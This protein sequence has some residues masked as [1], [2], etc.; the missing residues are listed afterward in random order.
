MYPDLGQENTKCRMKETHAAAV[1]D[2]ALPPS[3]QLIACSRRLAM[4]VLLADDLS[5]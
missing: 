4:R 5:G 2:A 3:M 1:S